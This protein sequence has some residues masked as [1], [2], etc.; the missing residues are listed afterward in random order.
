MEISDQEDDDTKNERRHC[1]E[2]LPERQALRYEPCL[3]GRGQH[4][5]AELERAVNESREVARQTGLGSRLHV[6]AGV[7]RTGGGSSPTGERPTRLLA[8]DWPDGDAAPLERRLRL[9]APPVIG[10][11][12]EGRLLLDLRTVLPGQDEVLA[13]R[14]VAE[15]RR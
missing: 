14:L 1:R 5:F 9:G 8:I 4:V 13:G 11:I 12:Q 2:D 6:V 10:R 3:H 7:S 15:L